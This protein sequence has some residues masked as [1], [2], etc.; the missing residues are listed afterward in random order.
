MYLYAY[1]YLYIVVFTNLCI[2]IYRRVYISIY[3][4]LTTC[5]SFTCLQEDTHIITSVGEY[6]CRWRMIAAGM[7]GRSGDCRVIKIV[8]R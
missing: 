2:Y 6:G 4:H 5:S 7:N 3:V 1:M 8:H